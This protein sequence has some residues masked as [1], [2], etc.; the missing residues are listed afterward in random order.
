[1]KKVQLPKLPNLQRAFRIAGGPMPKEETKERKSSVDGKSAE[2][3]EKKEGKGKF[4]KT[5]A[6]AN[7]VRCRSFDTLNMSKMQNIPFSTDKQ[8]SH[9]VQEKGEEP[10]EGD[11]F[12][13]YMVFFIHAINLE[14]PRSSVPTS[15][16]HG[17]AKNK[18]KKAMK[19]EERSTSD[20]E[21]EKKR[22]AEKDQSPEYLKAHPVTPR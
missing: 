11:D 18:L 13:V 8:C 21:V 20:N 17:Q 4:T 3:K 1:M 6:A 7:N 16:I 19:T 10:A 9:D 14:V 12:K 22:T 5:S 15:P 2:G